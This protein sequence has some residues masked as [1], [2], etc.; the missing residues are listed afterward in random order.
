[1]WEKKSKQT[2]GQNKSNKKRKY[3]VKQFNPTCD[4]KQMHYI[5][6]KIKLEVKL[7]V[8]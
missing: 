5:R 2:C 1:M 8:A 6:A 7:L 4:Y 3:Y